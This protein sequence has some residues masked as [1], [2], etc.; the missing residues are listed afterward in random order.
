MDNWNIGW[1]D[2]LDTDGSEFTLLD[3]GD[4][5]F[6]VTDMEKGYFSG[7]ARMQACNQAKLTLQIAAPDGGVATIKH[8][9][10]MCQSFANRYAAFLRSIGLKERNKPA[11]GKIT[12]SVGRVGRAHIAIREWVGNDGQTRKSNEVKY[13]ID[14]DKQVAPAQ[15]TELPSNGDDL[16]F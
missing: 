3:E 13:F 1:D 9:I 5:T 14:A 11:T 10:F 15:M 4:Y 12:D 8:N 2:I 6:V 7:S 16:P